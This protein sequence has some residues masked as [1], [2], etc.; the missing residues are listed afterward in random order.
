MNKKEIKEFEKR[1]DKFKSCNLPTPF[2]DKERHTLEYV[3][4]DDDNLRVNYSLY[5][6]LGDIALT[7]LYYSFTSGHMTGNLKDGF[8]YEV[9]HCHAHSFEEVVHWLY[10]YPESFSI[11]KDE[12]E[13]YSKQELDYLKNV[14]EYLLFIGLKDCKGEKRSK[15]RFKNKKQEKYKHYG[16][17]NVTDDLAEKILS[18]KRDYMVTHT[19][20]PEY[21]PDIKEY[22]KNEYV[23][24]ARN[25]EGKIIAL[26]EYAKELKKTYREFK[27]EFDE[28]I[29]DYYTNK[30]L[31]NNDWVI[32]RY[33]KILKKY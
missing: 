11:S 2:W 27:K 1:Y 10:D 6:S 3:Y 12:E 33:F 28:T 25:K 32:I 20:Y 4:F 13:F 19:E 8:R 26:L 17:T 24:F 18:G 21:Y 29:N 15:S 31:K 5:E 14:K 23:S 16:I 30:E 9:G 7:G 22:N